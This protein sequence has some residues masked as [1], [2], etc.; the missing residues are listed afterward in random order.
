MVGTEYVQQHQSSKPF[1]L[2]NRAT[3]QQSKPPK[4]RMQHPQPID[5]FLREQSSSRLSSK[6]EFAKK[7]SSQQS[8]QPPPS[9]PSL[10][11]CQ[12]PPL[13]CPQQS[14]QPAPSVPHLYHSGPLFPLPQ[15]DLPCQPGSQTI[16]SNPLDFMGWFQIYFGF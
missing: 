11:P 1:P 5:L 16:I 4:A 10:P 12:P 7:K 15:L 14:S 8:R 13:A 3:E 2:S 6:Y 9:A